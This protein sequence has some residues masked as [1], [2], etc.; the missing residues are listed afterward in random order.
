MVKPSLEA[1][2]GGLRLHG[3][4]RSLNK[5]M[6]ANDYVSGVYGSINEAPGP[7]DRP[8]QYALW[9]H[10]KAPCW[11][12]W[13]SSMGTST[14]GWRR[15]TS[16]ITKTGSIGGLCP[17]GC[18]EPGQLDNQTE[19]ERRVLTLLPQQL[20]PGCSTRQWTWILQFRGRSR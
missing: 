17:M 8:F 9:H 2:C 18:V 5:M 4:I 15:T 6:V 11:A 19:G 13:C 10:D 14:I 3:K 16:R 20:V 12:T 7:K 1:L